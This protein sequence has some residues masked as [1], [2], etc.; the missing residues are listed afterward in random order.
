M[1]RGKTAHLGE[2]PVDVHRFDLTEAIN[3]EDTLDVVRGVPGGVKD[4]DPV[5]SH[6]IDAEWTSSRRYE[7][8]TASVGERR[9][10]WI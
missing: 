6:Q 10:G 8:Q 1:F 7:K 9:E 3:S 5:G 2:E 4:D